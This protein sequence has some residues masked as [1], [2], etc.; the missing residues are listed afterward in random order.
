MTIF[1]H[2]GI[3]DSKGVRRLRILRLSDSG[4]V[5]IEVRRNGDVSF[6]I[7]DGSK[8]YG[9]NVA[10]TWMMEMNVG[11][12]MYFNVSVGYLQSNRTRPVIFTAEYLAP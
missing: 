6:V 1:G 5:E 2:F 3:S 8:E 9:A 10:Y 12:Y 11:E 7:S 4:P